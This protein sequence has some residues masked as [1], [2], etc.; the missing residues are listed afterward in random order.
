MIEANSPSLSSQVVSQEQSNWMKPLIITL[1][2]SVLFVV[3]V[4]SWLLFFGGNKNPTVQQVEK[5]IPNITNASPTPKPGV[6]IAGTITFEGYAPENSYLVIVERTGTDREFRSVVT[7]LLP[8]SGIIPWT[9]DDA[10]KGSNYELR[11]QLKIRGK[12]IQESASVFV[13]AP[14]EDVTLNLI[15]EQD[16]P[17]PVS[18]AISGTIHL[19]GYI[20]PKSTLSILARQTGNGSYN[21]VITNLAAT[22]NVKWTWADAV[23]GQTYDIL[24]QLKNAAGTVI[25][26]DPDKTITAPSSGVLFDISST[27]QPPTQTITGISGVVN[28]NGTIT[29]NSYVTLAQRKTGTATFSQIGTIAAKDDTSW[30]W[31]GANSGTQYDIQAYLWVDGKPFAQSNILT[32]TAPSSNNLMTI[33]AQLSLAAPAANTLN[34][35][36]NSSQ[37]GSFQATI[38]YN[39]NGAIQNATQYK[40]VVTNATNGSQIVNTILTPTNPSQTQSLTTGYQFTSGT[41][42]YAQY[43][44][45]NSSVFSPLSP[46]LQFS[47]K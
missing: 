42:F 44:Y 27:Y 10:T 46:S 26:T 8:E 9:W 24:V 45:S 47:C 30:S 5:L 19:D 1:T 17:K 15:S 36:C 35:T 4:M 33:N 18:A 12:T 39:T 34:V 38:A 28:I 43:A 29:S 37:N 7:G 41:T 11:T 22:S 3:A 14:A 21:P 20:P 40:I 32:V 6:S 23:S 31:N 25:S 2:I 16:P 13:S